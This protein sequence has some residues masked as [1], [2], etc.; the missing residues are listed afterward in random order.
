M[1]SSI[2][3]NLRGDGDAISTDKT[4]D[5][6]TQTTLPSKIAWCSFVTNVIGI[7]DFQL[8]KLL[9]PYQGIEIRA[10]NL[11]SNSI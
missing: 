5:S 11:E 2:D 1:D 4:A 6:S 8:Q 10:G 9:G 7:Y 3:A